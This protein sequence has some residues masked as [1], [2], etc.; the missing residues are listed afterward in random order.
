MLPY[1]I[2]LAANS[3]IQGYITDS[4]TGEALIGANIMLM[5][6]NMGIASDLDGAYIISD[7]PIGSY[8]LLAMFIG[9]DNLEKIISLMLVFKMLDKLFTGKKPPDEI[10]VM[11]K[12]NESKILKS[13]KFRIT[14]IKN[15]NKVYKINIFDDCFKVSEVLNDKKFVKDFFKLLSKMLINKIMENKKY[16]PPIH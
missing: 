5:D 15:V 10:S 4:K 12:L 11:D 8:T 3:T 1:T 14:K 6:T 2:C 13:R 9:Y 7:V 16:K